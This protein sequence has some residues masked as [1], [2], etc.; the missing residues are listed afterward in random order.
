MKKE[1]KSNLYQILIFIFTLA[2]IYITVQLHLEKSLN[3][4]GCTEGFNCKDVI[5]SFKILGVSNI[6]WGMLYYSILAFLSI[7][8]LSVGI[9]NISSKFK[10]IFIKLRNYLILFGFLYSLF[11]VFYQH[12]IIGQ[13][14]SLCLLSGLISITLFIL[15][16]LSGFLKGHPAP[17]QSISMLMHIILII[18]ILFLISKLTTEKPLVIEKIKTE[19]KI[20][21]LD[22]VIFG[23]PD[24]KITIIEWTDFQCPFCAESVEIIDSVLSKYPNDVRVIIKNYPMK[25]HKQAYKASQY[26]LAA[27]QQGKF[28]EMYYKIFKNYTNLRNNEDLPLQYAKELNLDINRFIIDFN[29]D[30]IKDQIE[31]ERRELENTFERISVPKFLI[32]G[33][34]PEKR[35]LQ[36]FYNMI[37]SELLK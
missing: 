25:S 17:D 15:L 24:A 9:K 16:I 28:K 27:H 34:V 3:F 21:I 1:Q 26:A 5:D 23:N 12:F 13:Y 11:L 2:G 37:D 20:P 22:S 14:C 7:G 35:N 18:F 31:R 8:T 36:T 10:Y 30:A 6:Y 4:E 32:Q 19:K 29:S 33:K